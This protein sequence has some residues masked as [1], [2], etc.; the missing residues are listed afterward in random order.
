MTATHQTDPT[1]SAAPVL[2]LALELGWNSW[3][4]AF[5]TGLGQSP[6]LRTIPARDLTALAGEIAKARPSRR[7]LG[8]EGST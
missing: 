3:K 1:T 6:R 5:T 7:N 8:L 4:L 2:Y